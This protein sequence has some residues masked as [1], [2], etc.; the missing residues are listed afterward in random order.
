MSRDNIWRRNIQPQLSRIG[1]GW[2]DFQVMRR[3]NANFGR[4]A[5]VDDKVAAD[6]RGHGVDVSLSTYTN[7]D[8]DDKREAVRKLEAIVIQ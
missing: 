5:R 6:Q 1:L 2:V 8:L 3:A 4:K 7:S